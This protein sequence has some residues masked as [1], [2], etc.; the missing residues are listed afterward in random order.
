MM[1]GVLARDRKRIGVWIIEPVGAGPFRKVPAE[2][3]D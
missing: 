3:F 1:G 2:T